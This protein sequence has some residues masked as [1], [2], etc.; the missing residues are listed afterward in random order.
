MG[1]LRAALAAATAAALVI[2]LSGCAQIDSFLHEQFPD[3]FGPERGAS[4]T[5]AAPV[6]AHAK[7]L[8]VGDCFDFESP[9]R[10]N[11][12]K[13]ADPTRVLIKPCTLDHVFEVIGQGEVDLVGE[14][15]LGLEVAIST[16]CA[17]PFASWA[18]AAPEGTR[19]DQEFLVRQEK[20][21]ER[22]TT[23]YTCIAAEQKL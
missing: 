9:D 20:V 13:T 15:T 10:D 1:P 11:P 16:Q 22:T 3:T 6:H 14:Q 4:G 21:G 18:S 23:L 19:T 8:V 5:V 12:A 2:G 7:Y 17:E